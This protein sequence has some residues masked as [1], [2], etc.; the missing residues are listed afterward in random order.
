VKRETG[1]KTSSDSEVKAWNN[2]G[3]IELS[4]TSSIPKI[5]GVMI[6]LVAEGRRGRL[7]EGEKGRVPIGPENRHSITDKPL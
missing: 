6:E 2:V 4:L 3:M 1:N 7:H 5:S